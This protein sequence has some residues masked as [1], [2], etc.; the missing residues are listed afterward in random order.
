MATGRH[1]PGEAAMS[2]I[3]TTDVGDRESREGEGEAGMSFLDRK[4][5]PHVFLTKLPTLTRPHL[6][7][8]L[9]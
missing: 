8:L 7:I 3:L 5:C 2:Y 6:L 4:D 9:K 1:S